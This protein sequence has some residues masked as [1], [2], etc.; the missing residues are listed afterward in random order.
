MTIRH[1][2][3]WRAEVTQIKAAVSEVD[4]QAFLIIGNAHEALGEGFRPLDSAI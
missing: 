3:T 2:F 1:G 4:P